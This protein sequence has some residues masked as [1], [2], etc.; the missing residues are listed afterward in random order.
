MKDDWV[1]SCLMLAA[2]PADIFSGA[3][4]ILFNRTLEFDGDDIWAAEDPIVLSDAGYTTNKLRHL[5]RLYFHEESRASAIKLWGIRRL[6]PSYGSVSFHC[7]NHFQKND[8]TKKSKRA[9]VMGPCLQSVVLTQIKNTQKEKLF[10]IDVFYRTT[11]VLKKFPADLV[12][13]RDVLLKGF[14]FSGMR[15][16]GMT[17]HFA[18]LTVH[19]MYFVTILPHLEDPCRELDRIRL[20]DK[21]HFD[22]IVKWTARYL[23]PKHFRG[24]QKHA[25]SMRVKDYADTALKGWRRRE[26]IKYLDENH[27]GHTRAYSP[28]EEKGDEE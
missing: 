7:Y 9:S 24:I 10:R 19:P 5:E 26:L 17:F 2:E 4:K 28:K 8:E 13:I 11:E 6:K 14:D 22:W 12:F 27:P 1:H 16:V 3:R 25:Q 23:V 21:H 18:N 20:V 15:C